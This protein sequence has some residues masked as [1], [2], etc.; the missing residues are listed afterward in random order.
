MLKSD[1][2]R[3]NLFANLFSNRDF[4]ARVTNTTN[5]AE[6]RVNINQIVISV[7]VCVSGNIKFNNTR[8]AF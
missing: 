5:Q 6:D 4:D 3:D 8:Y 7:T 1:L 2:R